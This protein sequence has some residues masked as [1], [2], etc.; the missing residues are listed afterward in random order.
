MET[1]VTSITQQEL[2][3][4]ISTAT[5]LTLHLLHPQ[6]LQGGGEG[7]GGQEGGGGGRGRGGRGGR[8]RGRG[9]G[10]QKQRKG[11]R[12]REGRGV[13]R[14]EKGGSSTEKGGSTEWASKVHLEVVLQHRHL[15]SPDT[16]TG[17]SESRHR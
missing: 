14:R 10:R 16:L 11:R 7:G 5:L 8:G 6:R 1:G 2:F 13:T 17:H 15:L 12:A 4:V 9:R 3:V